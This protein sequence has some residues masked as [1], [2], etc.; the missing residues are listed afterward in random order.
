MCY[1]VCVDHNIDTSLPPFDLGLVLHHWELFLDMT[2]I[3][4]FVP[5]YK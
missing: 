1:N 3:F 2:T 4:L 5:V